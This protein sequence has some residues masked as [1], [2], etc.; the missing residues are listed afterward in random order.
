MLKGLNELAK[1]FYDNAEKHGFYDVPPSF[2]ERMMLIVSE[3]SEAVE[4][5]RDKALPTDI[6]FTGDN[7]SK[8]DGIP[9]ELADILIRV[10]DACGYYG[11]DIEKAVA[12]KHQY[13]VNRPYKHGRTV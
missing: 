2:L 1:T 6:F 5:Y 12:L 4:H 9:V 11:I 7:K 8:P 3:A 10:L 13:N